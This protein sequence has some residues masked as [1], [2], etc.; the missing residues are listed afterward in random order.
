M[1]PDGYCLKHSGLH[2]KVKVNQLLQVDTRHPRHDEANRTLLCSSPGCSLVEGELFQNCLPS[3]PQ[4][5]SAMSAWVSWKVVD[6]FLSQPFK[7]FLLLFRQKSS[8]LLTYRWLCVVWILL[9]IWPHLSPHCALKVQI[10]CGFVH[11]GFPSTWHSACWLNKG[12][13]SIFRDLYG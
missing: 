2:G 1:R 7:C 11:H 9:S 3:A 4:H 10:T 8:S 6:K 5:L 12:I 13:K